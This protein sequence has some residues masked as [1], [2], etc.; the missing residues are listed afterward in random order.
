MAKASKIL[1]ISLFY[2]PEQI[3]ISKYSTEMAEWLAERG[4]EVRVITAFPFYPE[5][6]PYP[7]Y[8]RWW[9][10]TEQIHRVTVLRCPLWVPAKVT[11]LTRLLHLLTFALSSS[12]RILS[13]VSWQPEHVIA[14]MPTVTNWPATWLLARLS[15]STTQLHVQDFEFDLAMNL[16]ILSISRRWRGTII[17]FEEWLYESFD[18]VTTISQGMLDK[19]IKEKG[20]CQ[21]RTR[22]FPNWVDTEAIYPLPGPNGFRHSLGIRDDQAVVLYSG[23]MGRKYGLDILADAAQLL[24]NNDKIV[25]VLCGDGVAR[26]DLQARCA[27][28]PNVRFLPVQPVEKLNELLNAADIHALPQRAMAADSVMPSKLLGMLASGRPVV[29]TVERESEV[30]A[31][32]AQAGVTVKADNVAEFAAALVALAE[33]RVWRARLGYAGRQLAIERFGK[34]SILEAAFGQQIVMQRTS[35]AG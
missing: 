19:L 21:E 2:A 28:L 26:A 33:D 27:G 25:F 15:G 8:R 12:W 35:E 31:I 10:H 3:G 13:Q 34:N 32:V 7:G 11:G 1:I 20:I 29:A 14:L 4:A 6:K 18:I 30:G 16:N 9:Y 17:R 22:L 23:N 24:A 5:W